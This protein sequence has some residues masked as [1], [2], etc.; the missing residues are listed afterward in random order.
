MATRCTVVTEGRGI[1]P[2]RTPQVVNKVASNSAC[3]LPE[4]Y[5]T[6]PRMASSERMI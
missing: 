1:V 3:D 2:S 5:G 4:L 6:M